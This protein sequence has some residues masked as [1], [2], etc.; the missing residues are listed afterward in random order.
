MGIG[1]MIVTEK[2]DADKVVEELCKVG[3]EA[4]IIGEIVEGNKEVILCQD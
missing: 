2:E 3:E 4:T 1:M